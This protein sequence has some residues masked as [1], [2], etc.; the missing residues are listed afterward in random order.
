M[1]GP[2]WTNMNTSLAGDTEKKT[3]HPTTKKQTKESDSVCNSKLVLSFPVI[4]SQTLHTRALTMMKILTPLATPLQRLLNCLPLTENWE[5]SSQHQHTATVDHINNTETYRSVCFIKYNS[6]WVKKKWKSLIVLVRGLLLR[7]CRVLYTGWGALPLYPDALFS[8]SYETD[9][10]WS[11]YLLQS[12]L[13]FWSVWW[14]NSTLVGVNWTFFL[15][16]PIF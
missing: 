10:T 16:G 3:K 5:A 9:L 8:E 7:G 1:Q 13:R 15:M 6:C 2:E 14:T 4:L 12:R 11:L